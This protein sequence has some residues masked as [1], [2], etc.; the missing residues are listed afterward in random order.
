MVQA[1]NFEDLQEAAA[2]P[3]ESQV[4]NKVIQA[5]NINVPGPKETTKK[6]LELSLDNRGLIQL[7]FKEGGKLPVALSGRYTDLKSVHVDLA[8]YLGD[9]KAKYT[10]DEDV[11]RPDP[12][13]KKGDA[14]N[15]DQVKVTA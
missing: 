4:D 6:T 10:V 8:Q 11:K 15:K 12:N 9:E 2:K 5:I 14:K 3:E 1:V 13:D 7:R